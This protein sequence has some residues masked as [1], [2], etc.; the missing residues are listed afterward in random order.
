MFLLLT[1]IWTTLE[2]CPCCLWL[3]VSG[4]TKLDNPNWDFCVDQKWLTDWRFI[5]CTRC[6]PC[7][8]RYCT[9]LC[10]PCC[11]VP[12]RAVPCRALLCR[13]VPCRAVPCLALPCFAVPCRALLCRAVPCLALPCVAVPC[14]AV[15]CFPTLYYSALGI[16]SREEFW[17]YISY[18]VS[19]TLFAGTSGGLD[20]VSSGWG[21]RVRGQRPAVLPQSAPITPRR[22]VL[23]CDTVDY[24]S[25]PSKLFQPCPT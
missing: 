11:A 1:I 3:R 16:K 14:R 22:N 6:C 5:V 23:R 21:S 25:Y 9:L 12:C 20:S 19:N 2:S 24:S 10:V 7:S 18:K 15:P 13:A 4:D 17:T 8:N